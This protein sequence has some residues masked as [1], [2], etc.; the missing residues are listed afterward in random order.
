MQ[1]G[2]RSSAIP[3]II[4]AA[5]SLL[6]AAACTGPPP[7]PDTGL[8]EAE[9]AAQARDGASE[10]DLVFINLLPW[11]RVDFSRGRFATMGECNGLVRALPNYSFYTTPERCE[12]I[13]DPV[14]CTAWHDTGE[15]R[16]LDCFKGVGGCEVELKRHD[17]LA[18]SGGRT[19]GARCEPSPLADA[20]ARYQTLSAPD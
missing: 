5:L 7:A 10:P 8:A 18:E 4:A 15:P 9:P 20:W 17:L 19:I 12:P 16:R 6:H 1:S 13:E 14:Y 3:L 11:G 2:S